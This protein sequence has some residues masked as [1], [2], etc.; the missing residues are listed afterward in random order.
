MQGS[1]MIL[2]G[3]CGNRA[4]VHLRAEGTKN[5]EV[6]DYSG[7]YDGQ[8]IIYW[9]IL[10]CASCGEPTLEQ[11]RVEYYVESIMGEHRGEVLPYSYGQTT[12][13]DVTEEDVPIILD[14]LEA[15]LEYLYVAPAKVAA[16][17]VRLTKADEKKASPL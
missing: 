17:Q 15:I 7:K 5:G 10:E 16:L 3:H 8:T 2:C 13:D 4:I 1:K 6:P 12:L 14:F 11:T 9:R